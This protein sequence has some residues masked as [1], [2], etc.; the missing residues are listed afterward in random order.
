MHFWGPSFTEFRSNFYTPEFSYHDTTQ[1]FVICDKI[2]DI[3]IYS[4]NTEIG[5]ED[6]KTR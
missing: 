4:I 2:L 6:R 1:S 5:N 3:E